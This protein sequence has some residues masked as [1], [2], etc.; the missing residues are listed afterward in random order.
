MAWHCGVIRQIRKEF[1]K[2][3]DQ[4]HSPHSS[5]VADG[6]HPARQP[7]ERTALLVGELFAQA[8]PG[9]MAISHVKQTVFGVAD[10]KPIMDLKKPPCLDA[11]Y[12]A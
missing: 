8:A 11:L 2:E 10:G 3:G 5:R 7:S 4:G 12:K 9:R 6:Q 1:T